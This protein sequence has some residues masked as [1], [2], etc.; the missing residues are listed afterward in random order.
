MAKSRKAEEVKGIKPDYAVFQIV[1]IE[2]REKDT[3]YEVGVAFDNTKADDGSINLW[4][5]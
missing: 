2:G 1:E 5:C 4:K 3:F